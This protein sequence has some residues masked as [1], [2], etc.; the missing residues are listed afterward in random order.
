MTEVVDGNSIDS[1]SEMRHLIIDIHKGGYSD[2]SSMQRFITLYEARLP[3]NDDE[4]L[5]TFLS[6][7]DSPEHGFEF[8]EGIFDDVV[9]AHDKLG[10]S[11]EK[12]D[13]PDVHRNS[14]QDWNEQLDD[15][16]VTFQNPHS[17]GLRSHVAFMAKNVLEMIEKTDNH[18]KLFELTANITYMRSFVDA[19]RRFNAEYKSLPSESS[20][21]VLGTLS[22]QAIGYAHTETV[23][24][25]W[26]YRSEKSGIENL[27]LNFESNMSRIADLEE[28]RSGATAWL[29]QQ[30]GIRHFGRYPLEMLVQQFDKK[31]IASRPYGVI[32]SAAS[33]HNGA[34]NNKLGIFESLS[35]QL[36]S[37]HD[38]FVAEAGTPA[39]LSTRLQR[40]HN[41]NHLNHKLDFA[42]ISA[43]GNAES[44]Q[45]GHANNIGSLAV[46]DEFATPKDMFTKS[47]KMLITGCQS[48]QPDGIGHVLSKRLNTTIIAPLEDASCIDIEVSDSRHGLVLSPYFLGEN[49]KVKSSIFSRGMY[50]G[51]Y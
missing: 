18:D 19:I 30:Y 32:I 48:G 4:A 40:F 24:L 49:G 43:H 36:E 28:Q 39:E 44:L 27:H 15:M 13:F 5:E 16:L 10:G 17:V 14:N 41:V 38:I 3:R 22:L 51:S 7:L 12:L 1:M 25:D 37:S 31:G 23:H 45:F 47:G 2:V 33:D 26:P 34:L 11:I 50:M 9:S 46:K 29:S 8:W 6:S 21:M 35:R 42:I 20:F